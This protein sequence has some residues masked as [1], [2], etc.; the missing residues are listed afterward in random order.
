L[1]DDTHYPAAQLTL[2]VTMHGF[3][4]EK[5]IVSSIR[6]LYYVARVS[7]L[8]PFPFNSNF[9]V[10]EIGTFWLLY[11]VVTLITVLTCSITR[12]KQ[13][14]KKSGLLVAVMVNEFLSMFLG[15]LMAFSSILMSITRKSVISRNIVSKIIKVDKV[16]LNDSSTTYAKT[17]IFTLIQV[18]F[19]YSYATV[20]FT[21]DTVLWTTAVKKVSV[22]SIFTGYPHRLI[23]IEP[24][25]EFCDLVL[26]LI[27]R[28]KSLNSR[29]SLILRG[30]NE[31]DTNASVF[32]TASC[33]SVPKNFVKENAIRAPEINR[34]KIVPFIDSSQS[35]NHHRQQRFELSQHR[36]IR[37]AMMICVTLVYLSIPCTI[38]KSC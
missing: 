5:I 28:I 20:L 13:R 16:L 38:S 7:G 35:V 3:F 32:N 18:I 2:S 9:A 24:V 11:T 31:T 33:K 12:L 30:S 8:A 15:G 25:V 37:S 23:N 34:D 27:R 19:V 36:N 26:L 14:V 17:F 4:Q 29:L 1:K 6:P 21:Y 10:K 22:W